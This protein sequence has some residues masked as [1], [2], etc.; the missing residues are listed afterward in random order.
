LIPLA[1]LLYL[2]YINILD[3]PRFEVTKHRHKEARLIIE[4]IA[5][6]N[7]R[8]LSKFILK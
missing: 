4:K 7:E 6:A 2:A 5:M 1:V 3:S 8:V